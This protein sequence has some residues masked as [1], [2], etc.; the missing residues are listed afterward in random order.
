MVVAG[1]WTGVGFSNL[2][3]RRTRIQKF[4]NRSGVGVWKCDFGHLKNFGTGAESEPENVTLATF[5]I[6]LWLDEIEMIVVLQ[7]NVT[8]L[9]RSGPWSWSRS[10]NLFFYIAGKG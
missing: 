1:V 2:K 5:G 6:L 4:W 7:R 8:P 9:R 10:R 3:N